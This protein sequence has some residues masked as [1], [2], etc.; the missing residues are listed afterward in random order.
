V[1]RWPDDRFDALALRVFEWQFRSNEVYR[2]FAERRGATP[3]T[4]RSW[5]QV[6]AVP[7]TAFKHLPLVSGDPSR[8]E[9]VFRTSGTSQGRRR[10]EHHVPDLELYRGSLLPSFRAHVLPDGPMRFLSLIAPPEAVPDSSLSTMVGFA[11]SELG[12]PGSAWFAD[13]EHLDFGGVE[14]AL[15][16]AEGDGSPVLL[17]GTAF[18][19]VHWLDGLAVRG[20][21]GFRLPAGS[22]VLETGGFKGRSRVVPREDLYGSL[23]DRLGIAPEWIVNEYGM[24]ELLSQYYE[25][26]LGTSPPP[27][28]SLAHALAARRLVPPPWLRF[29][30]LDPVTLAPL[31]DGER[32]L[33]AHFDLANAGSVAAVLTEDVGRREGGGLQLFGRNPGAEPRG[34]SVAM[35]ELLAAAER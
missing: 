9:R 8:V 2:R 23:A 6:P 13:A 15:E 24:T 3:A 33:V 19:F 12:A 32:G 5:R 26:G 30:I 31:A 34:C 20:A 29:Q 1:D 4:V 35:D 25:A 22:R 14:R 7:A 18:A 11:M 28:V 16:A 17:L 10:G 21:S 27:G